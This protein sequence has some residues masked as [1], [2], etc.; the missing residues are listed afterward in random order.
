MSLPKHFNDFLRKSI[1]EYKK[2]FYSVEKSKQFLA[3]LCT[4]NTEGTLPPSIRMKPPK[5]VV[6]DDKA[7]VMLQS[8][9]RIMC[10]EYNKGL[11]ACYIQAQETILCN[12]E[13]KVKDYPSTFAANLTQLFELMHDLD[14]F[15][16]QPVLWKNTLDKWR[17]QLTLDFKASINNFRLTH[18]LDKSIER[19]ATSRRRQK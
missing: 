7:D 14:L 8:K 4:H 18:F 5:L 1:Q 10:D 9:M 3:K 11:L 2:L 12:Q 19:N 15:D 16:N 6:P 13:Q 17:D